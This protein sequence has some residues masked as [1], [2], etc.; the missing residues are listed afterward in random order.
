MQYAHRIAFF[1]TKIAQ[2]YSKTRHIAT[3]LI[4]PTPNCKIRF[5][6]SDAKKLKRKERASF[7]SVFLCQ[8]CVQS[9]ICKYIQVQVTKHIV[10][11]LKVD[12]LP[13]TIDKQSK[14]TNR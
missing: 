13:F 12:P 5:S 11:L 14:F 1:K 2:T 4:Y 7:F 10:H 9:Y 8:K 6:I 3:L